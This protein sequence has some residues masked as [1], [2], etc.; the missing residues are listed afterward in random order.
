MIVSAETEDRLALIRFLNSFDMT[1]RYDGFRLKYDIDESFGFN[2]KDISFYGEGKIICGKKSYI[3]DL[4]T[5]HAYDK[6]KVVIGN[7]CALSH[8]VRIY[9]H[10]HTADQDFSAAVK[11]YYTRDVI[12]EDFAW[13]GANVFISPGVKIGKNAIVG[14]NSVVT[15]DVPENAIVIGN[16]AKISGYRN[17]K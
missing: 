12:I 10:T 7:G 3:G 4:S 15:K 11:E 1:N 2:G 5:V 9:T 17:A 14:A 6:C 8:N 16:P 13:I